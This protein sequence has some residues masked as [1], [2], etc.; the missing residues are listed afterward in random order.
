LVTRAAVSDAKSFACAAASPKSRPPIAQPGR[1]VDETAGGVDLCR[2]VGDHEGDPFERPDRP[3]ELLAALDVGARG[4]EGHLGEPDRHGP[5]RDPAAV[6][7]SKEEVEAPTLRFEKVLRWN[8]NGVEDEL[9]GDRGM[10]A[11]A[12]PRAG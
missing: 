6:E 10:E 9:T 8:A 3:A 12:S 1:A 11:P 2:H 5:D 7:H 4:V